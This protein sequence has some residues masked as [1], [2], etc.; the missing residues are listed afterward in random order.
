MSAQLDSLNDTTASSSAAVWN[1]RGKIV[2]TP[3][4]QLYEVAADGD[5]YFAVSS[6]SGNEE[7]MVRV[8]SQALCKTTVFFAARFETNWM[9]ES[10]KFTPENPLRFTEDFDAFVTFLH[11]ASEHELIPTPPLSLLRSVAA[12]LDQHLFKGKLPDFF[13]EK[14]SSCFPRRFPFFNDVAVALDQFALSGTLIETNS[15]ALLHSAYLLNLPSVF[16]TAS[17]RMMWQMSV[18]DVDTLLPNDL[19]MLVPG[20]FVDSFEDEAVRL[21]E[22]LVSALPKVFYPDPHGEMQWYCY[23]CHLI[24][25]EERWMIEIIRKSDTWAE[26]SRAGP[27]ARLQDCFMDYMRMLGRLEQLREFD[28]RRAPCG[29]FR[30][31]QPDVLE[32]EMLFDVYNAIGGLCL[33]CVKAGG[34]F[35]YRRFCDVHQLDLTTECSEH[36]TVTQDVEESQA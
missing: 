20:D 16:A 3:D 34:E 25:H 10:G 2:Q 17:R 1:P 24:P 12:L 6:T 33:P 4:Y 36:E 9:P 7:V 21:R 8:S 30:L 26:E 11:I 29:R 28:G 18:V 35:R 23:F 13:E 15:L 31:R 27:V 19:R 5:A 14:L 32:R 22:D